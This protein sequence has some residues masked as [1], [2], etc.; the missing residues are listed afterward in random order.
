M[1]LS[2]TNRFYYKARSV[3]PILPAMRTS[4]L[5]IAILLPLIACGDDGAAAD[6]G[7][8]DA[9]WSR[10]SPGTNWQR[11]IL[12]YDL[13][14][15]LE[16]KTGTLNLVVAGDASTSLS[17]DKGSLT[18][19]K[20]SDAAGDLMHLDL[21]K[22]LQIGVPENGETRSIVIEYSFVSQTGFDGW[23][24]D[25]EISFLWPAFC[26]NLFPCNP[27]P[28]EGASFT[29]SVTGAS[30]MALY[31][32]SIPG[33]APSYMPA[34]AV[35]DFTERALGTTAAGTAV[36]VWYEPG[37]ESDAIAGTANL[38]AVFEFLETT[39]GAYSFGSKVGTV[40]ADWGGGDFGGMEH[41]PYWHVSTG[42]L[43]TEETN[44]HE[45]AHGWYGNGVRIACWEDYVLSEGVV[46]YMAARSLAE[47][48]VDLWPEYDCE[49]KAV[50]KSPENTTALLSTCGEIDLI[51]HELWSTSPYQKGAQYFREV[52][53]LLGE[54]VLDQA[55]AE[56]YQENVG[57]AARMRDLVAL[58][59]SK[60]KSSEIEAL[61]L[62][63]LET[64]ACPASA[65]SLCP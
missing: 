4:W 27:D 3:S 2:D 29:M 63:W 13:A 23:D 24:A 43:S 6:A 55:L 10:P 26:G 14:I 50:C 56:F 42:S 46:T 32:E 48:G 39:Y 65:D 30:Q 1:L 16:A 33:D 36:S 38:V 62:A 35:G 64:E 12:S 34:I 52:S 60:G 31:P 40:S 19:L 20:V 59:K 51:N 41:H 9:A 53:V 37:Q 57:K 45:A 8:P 22:E 7:A 25:K 49:L 17:L 18:I 5:P 15:D 58:L 11:D 28:A 54:D 21:G 61:T 47:S 44:A